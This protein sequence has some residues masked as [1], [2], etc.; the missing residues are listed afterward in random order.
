MPFILVTTE[1]N[2]HLL[3]RIS[4]T[5]Q[6]PYNDTHCATTKDGGGLETPQEHGVP[7]RRPEG[8]LHALVTAI[9]HAVHRWRRPTREGAGTQKPE[10]S[11][12]GPLCPAFRHVFSARQLDENQENCCKWLPHLGAGEHLFP[13]IC[14][15]PGDSGGLNTSHARALG[16]QDAHQELRQKLPQTK[17][18]T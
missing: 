6:G 7:T 16:P 18:N 5:S 2:Y 1:G 10:G 11:E 9:L 15:P 12:P 13:R 3:L 8:V 14:N 4:G 17:G